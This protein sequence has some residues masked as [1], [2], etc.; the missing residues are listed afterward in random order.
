MT[1]SFYLY[2]T[3]W[4]QLPLSIGCGVRA[5]KKRK[6]SVDEF[7]AERETQVARGVRRIRYGRYLPRAFLHRSKIPAR[8]ELLDWDG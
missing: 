7:I 6:D 1:C 5:A 2:W 8:S 4:P 3:S